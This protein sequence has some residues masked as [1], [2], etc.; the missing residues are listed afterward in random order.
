MRPLPIFASLSALLFVLVP[1]CALVCA[2]NAAAQATLDPLHA[3]RD[4]YAAYQSGVSASMHPDII[5]VGA[6]DASLMRAA[7]YDAAQL[8]R[9]RLAYEALTAAQSGAFVAGVQARVR[10]AGRGAVL[11]QLERD[12]T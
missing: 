11:R 10:A 5:S 4:P 9:G 8:A 1:V 7:Q 12:P 2:A 3:A 6:M